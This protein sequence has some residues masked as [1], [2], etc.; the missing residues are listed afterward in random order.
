MQGHRLGGVDSDSAPNPVPDAEHFEGA[1]PSATIRGEKKRE[2]AE[3]EAEAAEL[4]GGVKAR[5][6]VLAAAALRRWAGGVGQGCGGA[7]D[8][9]DCNPRHKDEDGSSKHGHMTGR[10]KDVNT[11][12]DSDRLRDGAQAVVGAA[13]SERGGVLEGAGWECAAC[14]FINA[15]GRVLCSLCDSPRRAS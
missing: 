9:G 3:E 15:G 8:G 2:R 11:A 13:E 4:A 1:N 14:T 5:R 12:C 7:E 6:P 10:K